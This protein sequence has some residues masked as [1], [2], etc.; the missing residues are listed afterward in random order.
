[1]EKTPEIENKYTELTFE[2][3]EKEIAKL[4]S[5]MSDEEVSKVFTIKQVVEK[6]DS[7]EETPKTVAP[8]VDTSSKLD[9][10]IEQVAQT[11]MAQ[12]E[13]KLK[14]IYKDFDYS[15]IKND[16]TINT[17]QKVTL[18]STIA[19]PNAKKMATIEKNL[20]N[21]STEGTGK[22]ETKNAEF[23]APE[24]KGKVDEKAGEK[25]YTEMTE[26]LGLIEDKSDKGDNK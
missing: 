10:Q 15:G 3:K 8:K 21:E 6:K 2:D 17:L 5:S 14:T 23:S 18:M 20:K 19:E 13:E 25:F 9:T 24:T 16:T 7:V 4:K 12:A 1:M 11:L 22:T 26:K